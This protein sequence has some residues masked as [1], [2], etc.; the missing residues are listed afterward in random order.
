MYTVYRVKETTSIPN[1]TIFIIRINRFVCFHSY[2]QC[3]S[4][5]HN[6]TVYRDQIIECTTHQTHTHTPIF[7]Y[8]QCKML[9]EYIPSKAMSECNVAITNITKSMHINKNCSQF[10][11][12][13]AIKTHT[14][15]R[16]HV[17]ECPMNE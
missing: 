3:F 2:F 15:T 17:S 10:D 7:V 13:I 16:I 1:N 14:H 4:R 5:M 6:S 8:K 9:L 11:G 12:Y